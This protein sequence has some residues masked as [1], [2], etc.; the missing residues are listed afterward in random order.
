[1]TREKIRLRIVKGALVPADNRALEILRERSF[2]IGDIVSADITKP[3]NVRFNALV[4][5][6]GR[7][8]VD[9]VEAFQTMTPHDAIK[10]L[11]LESGAGCVEQVV[12]MPNV[13]KVKITQPRSL[14]FDSMDD[15]ELHDVA[16]RICRY[17]SET[18]WQECTP[19]QVQ[20]MAE[21]MI[22]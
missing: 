11:Q 20:A 3:R 19:E 6:I 17:V 16:R 9:N 21:K 14:S 13:G 7:L 15:G 10:R 12:D 2:H 8:V 18:Y 1:M 22:D 5:H 4:H